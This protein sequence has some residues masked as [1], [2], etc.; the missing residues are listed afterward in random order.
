MNTVLQ[1]ELIRFNKLL[2][3]IRESITNVMKAIEGL[4]VMSSDLEQ[5]GIGLFDN[6]L[7]ALW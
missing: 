2:G 6:I 5:V 3:V 4:I 7:P 1:Q